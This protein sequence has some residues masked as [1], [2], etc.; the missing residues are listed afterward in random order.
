MICKKTFNVYPSYAERGGGLYC[1]RACKNV[2][3]SQYMRSLPKE[4]RPHYQGKT[5]NIKC[6]NCGNEFETKDC[7]VKERNFCSKSCSA[8]FNTKLRPLKGSILYCKICGKDFYR[9]PSAIKR[10]NKKPRYCSRRCRAIDSVRH[11][12]RSG[13]DIEQRIESILSELNLKFEKQKA[14]DNIC[15]VD[16]FVPPNICIFADGDYWH[17]QKE[18]VRIDERQNRELLK[19]GYEIIRLKG[20]DILAD[21]VKEELCNITN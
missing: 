3:H 6:A 19:A 12:R 20:K 8:S 10:K 4:K 11:Q 9:V 1:S 15:L 14:I 7:L 18:R 5:S 16:F 21:N 17:S 2:A 13:T